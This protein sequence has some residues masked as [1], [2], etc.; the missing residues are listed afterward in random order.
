ML[1]AGRYVAGGSC[2]LDYKRGG[3]CALLVFFITL[4]CE[5]WIRGCCAMSGSLHSHNVHLALRF[6]SFSFLLSPSFHPKSLH[7]HNVHS[8]LR[9]LTSPFSLFLLSPFSFI[10]PLSPFS[11]LLDLCLHLHR[12]QPIIRF[13]DPCLWPGINIGAPSLLPLPNS[14]N[15]SPCRASTSPPQSLTS[16]PPWSAKAN[17]SDAV[18]T[19]L[20]PSWQ[21]LLLDTNNT[22]PT[23]KTCVHLLATTNDT[24]TRRRPYRRPRR[25]SL[26]HA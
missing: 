13:L 5:T 8:P 25:P 21:S 17:V 10:S 3:W 19:S 12:E 26:R 7:S 2:V 22:N 9:P 23:P 20:F 1:R 24:D 14:S 18:S 16:L 6:A 4:C 15:C 11:F